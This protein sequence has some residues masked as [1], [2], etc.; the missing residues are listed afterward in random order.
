MMD[1]IPAVGSAK[2]RGWKQLAEHNLL[3]TEWKLP[4]RLRKPI[5]GKDSLRSQKQ[6]PFEVEKRFIKTDHPAGKP[7]R[8]EKESH[9][10]KT[11]SE[12]HTGDVYMKSRPEL[13]LSV[14][15]YRGVGFKLGAVR[16]R[17]P[18]K[19]TAVDKKRFNKKVSIRGGE[20]GVSRSSLEIKKR[21]SKVK[22]GMDL[23]GTKKVSVGVFRP[24]FHKKDIGSSL[25]NRESKEVEDSGLKPRVEAEIRDVPYKFTGEALSGDERVKSERRSVEEAGVEIYGEANERQAGDRILTIP[26]RKI[27]EFIERCVAVKTTVKGTIKKGLSLFSFRGIGLAWPRAV[28]HIVILLSLSL[29]VW[30]LVYNLNQVG[31]GML[32]L[33]GVSGAVNSAYDDIMGA[34]T[35]MAETNLAESEQR[36]IRAQEKLVQAQKGMREAL[37][38]SGVIMQYLD[39]TGTVRSGEELLVS[40]EKLSQAGRHLASG[41]ACLTNFNPQEVNESFGEKDVDLSAC[42][43]KF[44]NELGLAELYLGEA[45]ESLSRADGLLLPNDI[46]EKVDSLEVMVGKLKQLVSAVLRNSDALRVLLGV[47]R[48]K[49]YLLLF[50]NNH[51]MRPTGGFIGS[52]GLVDVDRGKVEEIDIKSVY[53]PDGQLKQFII[54]PEPLRPIANRW[55]MRD[56][57]WFVDYELSAKKIAQFFEKEGGPTVDGVIALNPELI[58][59]FLG[60]VGPVEMKEYQVTVDESN[61]WDVTQDQ[62]SYSYDKQLN[63]P[64]RFIADLAPEILDRVLKVS[65]ADLWSVLE[66]INQAIG[67]KNLLVY[68]KDREL[69]EKINDLG[70][71]GKLPKGKRGLLAVNNANIGG[72]KSDQFIEQEIDYRLALG[73]SRE[74]DVFV[75]VRRTHNGPS[76]GEKYDYPDKENP[77]VKDNVVWQRV[78]VPENAELVEARGFRS[79]SDVPSYVTAEDDPYWEPDVDVWEWSMNQKTHESGTVIGFESGYKYFANWQI[80]PPGESTIGMYHYRVPEAALMPSMFDPVERFEVYVAKQPG[81]ERTSVRIELLVPESMQIMEVVPEGGITWKKDNNVVYRGKLKK[82]LLL[83]S[84]YGHRS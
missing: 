79:A 36:F 26:R 60:L 6:A 39:V 16:K 40:G 22:G 14:P 7:P 10:I 42:L 54:P 8:F 2:K 82:D 15:P 57:N 74:V 75:T 72:H 59:N 47:D 45:Q 28:A 20:Q 70:W 84:V 65:G 64:K 34:Q 3:R 35:A 55:Y 23:G 24:I 25:P 52:I 1:I 19:K 33:R 48:E 29:V 53:D 37:S 12:Y 68:F 63:Q 56:A 76:E 69:Q 50:Q 67:E 81:D 13:L 44:V 38:V 73:S 43:E 51:E 71:S 30:G 11:S 5:S 32:A 80:T 61:F 18:N 83:G 49:Q 78:L 31:R 9:Y 58:S 66:I 27:E 77:A 46:R 41:V 17:E 62:V 4:A 21:V